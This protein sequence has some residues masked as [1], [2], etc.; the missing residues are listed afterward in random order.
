MLVVFLL[1][2]CR[3]AGENAMSRRLSAL[4]LLF[5]TLLFANAL[6]A[7][8]P[9]ND[10]SFSVKTTSTKVYA[11]AVVTADLNGDGVPDLIE[12]YAR[13]GPALFAVQLGLG[14]GWF[15]PAV[16][17][18]AAINQQYGVQILT[19]D[20]NKDGKA[21]VIALTGNVL[22]VYLGRGDG[23]LLP[24]RQYALPSVPGYAAVADFNRDG[25]P[26]LVFSI[27]G[28]GV[29]VAYGDGTGAF[30]A[31]V[32]V[33]TITSNQTIE[34]IAAGDFDG[35]ANADISVAVANGPCTMGGCTSCD[36]HI[37]Y[38]NGAGAFADK[39]VYAGVVGDFS[40]S[41]GDLNQDGRADL[42]GS[43][44]KVTSTG[45]NIL[46]LYG[47]SSRSVTATYLKANGYVAFPPFV[48]ADFNG[49]GRNDLALLA[50]DST[51]QLVVD[52]F[53]G[54]ANGTFTQQ[55]IVFGFAPPDRGNLL[56]G[57]FDR[58]RKPDLL[59]TAS[60]NSDQVFQVFDYLNTTA[61]G[62]WSP[63]LYPNAAGGIVT[64]LFRSG[65][66]DATVRLDAAA[67][68]FEPLRKLELWVDGVKVTEQHNV[69]DKYAW[70]NYAHVYGAGT[71]RA[72]VFSAGYD[73]ALQHQLVT[74][75]VP[76]S[77]CPVP[78]AP[79]VH[80]CGPADGSVLTSPVRSRAGG[81]VTG[82][83]LRMEVWVDSTKM[84][85]TFGSSALDATIAVAPGAHAFSYYVVNTVG[86]KWQKVVKVNV[87]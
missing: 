31:P 50:E 61:S 65:T 33:M 59:L 66:N 76:G 6:L 44:S 36:V 1:P 40:F 74:F 75:T 15:A 30:S 12:T 37:L 43:L 55:E 64:C 45:E 77:V 79:G 85:S 10:A 21:D 58:D 29:S 84:Y 9:Q 3:T 11:T 82:T 8:V 69:W 35:D 32:S 41:S 18:T 62:S 48:M 14:N 56:V 71:H 25:N 81:T 16:D 27:I 80:V 47:Q 57:D 87:R 67:A 7:A 73:N 42:M 34:S 22:L 13:I 19:A 28:G 70:L 49:D 68:G 53:L 5:T 86:T 52:V 54:G 60:D 83:I 24:P 4:S 39:L 51:N 17:Y 46:V 72:D 23:T 26:D 63:C 20:V 38:G 78:S 2:R